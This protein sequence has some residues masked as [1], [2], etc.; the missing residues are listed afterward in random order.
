MDFSQHVLYCQRPTVG[1]TRN[2]LPWRGRR[3]PWRL[4]TEAQSAICIRCHPGTWE[5]VTCFSVVATPGNKKMLYRLVNIIKMYDWKNSLMQS[6]VGTNS[7]LPEIIVWNS[8]TIEILLESSK[9]HNLI[10][11]T[12]LPLSWSPSLKT[13]S[14]HVGYLL[15]RSSPSQR[16]VYVLTF[17]SD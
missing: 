9:M 14:R 16:L 11:L 8:I 10:K 6:L 4:V 3:W 1:Q 12:W 13:C 17:S 2:R 7:E 5:A 15:L